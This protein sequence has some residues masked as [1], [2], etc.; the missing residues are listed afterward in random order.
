MTKPLNAREK[1]F[2]SITSD[3]GVQT[4]GVGIMEGVALSIAPEANVIHL[5][6]G[7]PAF[8]ITA[9]ARTLETVCYLPVGCHVCVCDPG[10][11]TNRKALICQVTRGDY[12]IGP[13][14]GVLIPASRVLGG[15]VRVHEITNPKYMKHPISPI[16]HGRDIFMPAAAYL[17]T[18]V[19][20][21]E[22][23][24]TIDPST[25]VAASYDEA[26][27]KDKEIHA[28]IIQINRFGSLHLNILHEIWDTF[29]LQPGNQV[30]LLLPR[31][32][33][34]TL[35]VCLTFGDV[36]EG[37]VLILKDDYGRVE[38]AKNMGSFVEQYP[39]EIGEKVI[40]CL[41]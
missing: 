16:F 31:F 33:E 34:L 3:F 13:D 32:G 9:A 14:N 30:T 18:G 35:P 39:V 37:E 28:Q 21:T 4:Q 6:H 25:L 41:P 22:F 17:A 36:P 27:V 1:A 23:G 38:V 40:L 10:V 15:L 20:I 7:L 26:I 24:P 2:I 19:D 8:D 12:L 11:G 5:M 29:D